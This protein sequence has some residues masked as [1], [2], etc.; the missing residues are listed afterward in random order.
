[1]VN[2]QASDQVTQV[3]ELR[4][5]LDRVEVADPTL[6]SFKGLQRMNYAFFP[7]GAGLY[8]GAQASRFPTN[9]ILILGSNFGSIND[10]MNEL[11]ELRRTDERAGRTWTGLLKLLN[12]SGIDADNCFFTNA[13]PFLHDGPGNL[14]AYVGKWLKNENLMRE[15]VQFFR[16][17][18][19]AMQPKLIVALG[20]G[21]AAFLS[22]I[23]PGKLNHWKGYQWSNIEKGPLVEVS[24][25]VVCVSITHPSMPNRRHR[26]NEY[27]TFAGEVEL[28]K[29]AVRIARI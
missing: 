10:F 25:G 3:E 20:T 19:N 26:C 27:N 12:Q 17:T 2:N 21:P 28:L 9:G 5:Y 18:L 24:V 14:N 11:G 23:W 4:E 15:C 13:W 16:F 7:G 29:K 1:L 8:K 6:K 22:Y